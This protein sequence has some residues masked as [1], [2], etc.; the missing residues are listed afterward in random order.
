MVRRLLRLRLRSSIA[1]PMSSSTTTFKIG[2]KLKIDLDRVRDR[3]PS[4]LSELLKENPRGTVV[5]FKMTD[6]QGIGV[7]LELSDGSKSWFFDEE[8]GRG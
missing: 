3:I 6:G 4:K 8:V 2:S 7:V 5:N 1:E